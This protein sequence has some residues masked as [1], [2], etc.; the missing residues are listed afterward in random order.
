M[1]VWHPVHLWSSSHVC[2]EG[3]SQGQSRHTFAVALAWLAFS[4]CPTVTVPMQLKANH[5][6]CCKSHNLHMTVSTH[7]PGGPCYFRFPFLQLQAF[8]NLLAGSWAVVNKQGIVV[9]VPVNTPQ[10]FFLPA[11]GQKDMT[12]LMQGRDP[13]LPGWVKVQ[14][15]QVISQL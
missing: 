8:G 5:V 2:V 12:L 9:R 1:K 15:G 13:H 11:F 6:N 4:L 7:V 10:V 3:G 14:S